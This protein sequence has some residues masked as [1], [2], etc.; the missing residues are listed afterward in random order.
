MQRE[1]EKLKKEILT[2]CGMVEDSV[3]LAVKSVM[4]RDMALAQRVID[5]D[6]DIDAKE[7]DVEEE[8][9]KIL[10]LYQPV[11]IDLRV[12][13]AVLKMNNDLERI[14][15]L[16]VNIAE[17]TLFL[18]G[19]TPLEAP[20]NFLEMSNKSQIMLRQSLDS[21]MKSD[22]ALAH[23]VILSDDEVDEMNR[24]MYQIIMEGI[25]RQPDCLASYISLL[26]VSRHLERI[27]DYATNIAE[28]VIYMIDGEIIRHKPDLMPPFE[29]SLST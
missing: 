21:L 26:S 19:E 29:D 2:L 27:A 15:D 6:N 13:V 17:R 7:V 20:L 14:G 16:A 28:D 9:L 10:A 8:C 1:L 12:V 18:V 5:N 24:A 11:A 3:H 25:R 22:T 23:R 4:E